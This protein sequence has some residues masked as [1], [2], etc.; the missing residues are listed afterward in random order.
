MATTAAGDV[1]FTVQSAE[2]DNRSIAER[3]A[4]YRM[5]AQ[6]TEFGGAGTV[7]TA[8]D[9]VM[10]AI[11]E[12]YVEAIMDSVDAEFLLEQLNKFPGAEL[13]T[14]ILLNPE[15]P[16]PPLFNPPLMDFMKTLELDFCRGNFDITF[17]KFQKLNIPDLWKMFMDALMEVLM[18]LAIKIIMTILEMILKILLNGL[19]NL[20][21]L[22]GDAV[23][24]LF[25]NQPSNSFADS[26]KGAATGTGL[27]AL[28]IPIPLADDETVNAAAADLFG[29][30]SRSCTNPEDLPTGDEAS[31]FMKEIGLILTQGEFIDLLQG[32][33]ASEVYRAVYQL[34]LVRHQ[35]FLCI[36]PNISSIE[37][38][39]GSL[40]Q[41]V[42]PN[43]MSRGQRGQ[44]VF[45]GVC[46]DVSGSKEID[47]LRRQLLQ[48]QG[49][50]E[51]LIDQQIELLKCQAI[52]DLEDLAKFAN[53]GLSLPP[54]MGDGCTP[55]ILPRDPPA[56][57]LPQGPLGIL[58]GPNGL[59]EGSFGIMDKMYYKDL[60][61]RG[62]FL[63]MVLSDKD[64]R[65]RRNHDAFVAFS[66]IFGIL[67]PRPNSHQELL[68][69]TV[70]K[71]L[72]WA[73]ANPGRGQ[74][75]NGSKFMAKSFTPG[76]SPD[77]LLKY[78]NYFPGPGL[79]VAT[80]NEW[81]KFELNFTASDYDSVVLNNSY[82][83]VLDETFNYVDPQVDTSTNP[84]TTTYATNTAKERLIIDTDP[85]MP[86]GVQE[87]IEEEL[88]LDIEATLSGGT[89]EGTPANTLSAQS[90]V[91][92]KYIEKILRD[93]TPAAAINHPDGVA[94]DN[95]S[96]IA[97]ACMTD[98][99]NYINT[100]FFNFIAGTISETNMAFD[101]GEG[102]SAFDGNEAITYP[103]TKI[104]LDG[105]HVYPP[106]HPQAGDPLP[107]DPLAWG[108]NDD[109]PAYYT[110]PPQDRPGWC[111]IADKMI[112]E[113]D[114]C[115]PKRE[116][117]IGFK[118]ISEEAT[119]F[120]Q[121]I[122]DDERL[123]QPTT[124]AIEEPCNK[125][126]TRA[127][128]AMIEGNL[129]S[130]I[131][132]YAAE[133]FLKGMPAFL[134]F[135]ADLNELYGDPMAA[136]IT[137]TLKRGFYLYSKKGFGRRRNDEYYFQFLEQCVQN[138]GRKVDAGLIEATADEQEA[139]DTINALQQIW[140]RD[141]D[142]ASGKPYANT[143]ERLKRVLSPGYLGAQIMNIAK[144]NYDTAANT[145]SAK[146]AEKL[147]E[148][149]WDYFMREITNPAEVLA[150]RYIADELRYF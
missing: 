20:L 104:F 75:P 70:A 57:I 143:G 58:Q 35:S 120:Y 114:A 149:S 62:G 29:A 13:I 119:D 110:R 97:D 113:V 26:I 32:Q 141:T 22:L 131:R 19:C 46:S 40:G 14:K 146:E 140:K 17:P 128:A 139:L 49:L 2:D 116:N 109:F 34:V 103:E 23:A 36:F 111:G 126:L 127:A 24:G 3:T 11:L 25:A 91:F 125:I 30:F 117:I 69:E 9:N 122:P 10:D 112:P 1:T 79:S 145:M 51:E 78:S 108:G 150:K 76:D 55:G 44:P 133:A 67:S 148:E 53:E 28:G 7:G 123:N 121:A 65:S 5:E 73:L 74:S 59:F 89:P 43:F 63:N 37:S 71:Y 136:Y 132:I 85:G 93:A 90:V 130:T 31:E 52:S 135:K 80:E 134:K 42:D 27:D 94:L 142:P 129:R 4:S 138:F 39:F 18:Q 100:T 81:Y 47:D 88:G 84:P 61:G 137:E 56:D 21:G 144:G 87:F 48:N 147:K 98:M 82:R 101:Y 77:M 60:M 95:L 50:N 118:Q 64:G 106:E 38:F 86:D 68:P 115:D 6:G 124:C 54:L 41:M 105:T 8:A 83:I 45:P 66:A 33:A 16:P 72:E 15:C 102:G 92:G 96:Y 99:F 12:A 107:L